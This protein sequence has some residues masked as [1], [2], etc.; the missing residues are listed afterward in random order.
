MA[1]ELS[2]QLAQ[3]IEKIEP[4]RRAPL[5]T[6]A[7]ID[8]FAGRIKP[9]FD[10]ANFSYSPPPSYRAVLKTLGA[11]ECLADA[12]SGF[13]L[14]SPE[15]VIADT[16]NLVHVPEGVT[17][18]DTAGNEVT[19]STNHFVAFA[20]WPPHGEGRWVF[21]ISAKTSDG[22][23]PVHFH[24]QDRPVG[25]KDAKTGEW[26]QPKQARPRFANFTVWL[27]VAVGSYLKTRR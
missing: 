10:S 21:D 13:Q 5:L 17:W 1:T 18:A 22:E 7:Q 25:A 16:N 19:I 12:D 3:I 2:K 11:I 4:A 14:L 6:D 26:V 8:D 27:G 24:E 15:A 9:H 20:Q 23:Y